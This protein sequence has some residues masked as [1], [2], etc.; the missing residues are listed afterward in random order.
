M[1]AARIPQWP[2][3]LATL[4]EARAH[5]PFAWGPNDCASFVAD[6][7]L[8]MTDADLLNEL[9]GTRRT[10]RAARQQIKRIGGVSAVIERA[11]LRP[12][13]VALAQRGDVLLIEQGDWPVLAVCNGAEALGTG[14]EGL[15]V[16]TM[17]KVVAAW[18]V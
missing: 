7:V 3:A 16:S 6:A 13:P 9:R 14:I 11:G 10:I 4:I 5:V 17:D 2:A 18:R 8:A 1:A 12:V 15:A